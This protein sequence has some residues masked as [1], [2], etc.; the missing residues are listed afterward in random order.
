[1]RSSLTA[2]Q[3]TGFIA[4]IL[5]AVV[6]DIEISLSPTEV[7]IR[8]GDTTLSLR[9]IVTLSSESRLRVLAVGE[10]VPPTEPIT[11]IELFNPQSIGTA[12][13]LKYEC[14]KTFFQSGFSRLGRRFLR[15]RVIVSVSPE[16][17]NLFCG[18]EAPLLSQAILDAGAYGCVFK[19][20]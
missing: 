14:L 18:Y 10:K 19:T 9:P 6:K 15:P 12:P 16:F 3:D 8:K 7:C 1:V 11:E 5:R 17:T 20:G 2:S 13:Y 4:A